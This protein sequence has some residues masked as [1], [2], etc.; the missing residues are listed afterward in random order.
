MRY[1]DWYCPQVLCP[2]GN[3]Y[4]H[5]QSWSEIEGG[6]SVNFLCEEGCRFTRALLHHEGITYIETRDYLP[7]TE[8]E[9]KKRYDDVCA[10]AK[11]AG[12]DRFLVAGCEGPEL[13][14]PCDGVG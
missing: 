10:A 13:D 5:I 4:T 2:C 11:A 1:H 12:L 8:T 9:R 3:N 14:L 6:I 7:L